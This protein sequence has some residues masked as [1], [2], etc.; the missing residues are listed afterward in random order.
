VQDKMRQATI[1]QATLLSQAKDA[2]MDSV[3]ATQRAADATAAAEARERE[4]QLAA[5]KAAEVSE[6]LQQA[7]DSLPSLKPTGPTT[8]V[9]LTQTAPIVS[10]TTSTHSSCEC[11]G[12]NFDGSKATFLQTRAV[13]QPRDED[14]KYLLHVSIRDA[15][16]SSVTGLGQNVKV[17]M[18]LG[19]V[20]AISQT[21]PCS[22]SGSVLAPWNIEASL[23]VVKPTDMLVLELFEGSFNFTGFGSADYNPGLSSGFLGR[24]FVKIDN[25]VDGHISRE[26]PLRMD[27]RGGIV[28]TWLHMEPWASRATL[29]SSTT[30]ASTR[31][32]KHGNVQRYDWHQE[33]STGGMEARGVT[34]D[35]GVW[36]LKRFF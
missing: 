25:L 18:V 6:H 24:V 2:K 12:S 36:Y 34:G 17:R 26:N 21:L 16:L 33:Q 22:G 10:S 7:S 28:H 31:H 8:A 14:I 1:A 13:R 3:A 4:A 20:E 15:D 5:L 19:D 23:P 29:S 35:A 32:Y 11:W 30:S 27:N 9:L